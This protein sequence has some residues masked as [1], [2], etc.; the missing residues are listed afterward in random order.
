MLTL[1]LFTG[2]LGSYAPSPT[3]VGPYRLVL[4]PEV[5]PV[6]LDSKKREGIFVADFRTS[7][8]APYQEVLVVRPTAVSTHWPDGGLPPRAAKLRESLTSIHYEPTTW[9]G[10]PASLG[11]VVDPNGVARFSWIAVRGGWLHE[12]QCAADEAAGGAASCQAIAN[13]VELASPPPAIQPLPT[14][15]RPEEAGPLV[16]PVPEGWT[17]R[18]ADPATPE[19]VLRAAPPHA[20]GPQAPRALGELKVELDPKVKQ[21]GHWVDA[22]RIG[23]EQGGMEIVNQTVVDSTYGKAFRNEFTD[24]VRTVF[25]FDTLSPAGMLHVECAGA[26]ARRDELYPMCLGVFQGVALRQAIDGAP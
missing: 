6:P 9:L 13:R 21:L 8:G 26:L 2:C 20:A 18:P 25:T 16:V 22:L 15:F 10:G 7:E 14:R 4:P 12:L 24:G 11:A 17:L 23:F 3:E 1:L 5:A 19:Q